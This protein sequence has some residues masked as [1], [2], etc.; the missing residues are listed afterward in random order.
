MP[1][2]TDEHLAMRRR[3]ILAAALRRFSRQGFHRTTMQDIVDESGLS[4]GGVYRYFKSKDDLIEALASETIGAFEEGVCRVLASDGGGPADVLAELFRGL[5]GLDLRTERTRLALQVW[6]E[7]ARNPTVKRSVRTPF[8]R[9]LAAIADAVR[10][11]QG[12]R[13]APAA[14]DP[15]HAARVLLAVLQG[16]VV[17]SVLWEDLDVAAYEAAAVRLVGPREE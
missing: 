14:L 15:D 8:E 13:R 5:A 16:L 1:K 9:V 11:A 7:A 10:Q 3:E 6:A 4:P 2:V 12:E 17:Q